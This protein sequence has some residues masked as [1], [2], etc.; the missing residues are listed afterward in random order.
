MTF[1]LKS[2]NTSNDIKCSELRVFDVDSYTSSVGMI[3]E[4]DAG[5]ISSICTLKVKSTVSHQLNLR[6][7]S[8]RGMLGPISSHTNTINLS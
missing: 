4:V 3:H 1:G 6:T 5:L 8:E 7:W 2:G